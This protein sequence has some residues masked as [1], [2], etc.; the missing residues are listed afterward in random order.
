V[1]A[2]LLPLNATVAQANASIRIVTSYPFGDTAAV[3]VTAGSL[4]TTVKIRIP[5]EKRP[6]FSLI[7]SMKND[8]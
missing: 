2:S 5:G 1:I 8:D 3:V 7:F 6:P 4:V